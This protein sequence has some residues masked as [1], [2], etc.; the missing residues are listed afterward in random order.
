VVGFL[1]NIVDEREGA[2]VGGQTRDIIMPT[3]WTG[4]SWGWST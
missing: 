2:S 3:G 4:R 1:T